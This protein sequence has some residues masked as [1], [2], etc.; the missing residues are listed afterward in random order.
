MICRSEQTQVYLEMIYLF[1][2]YFASKACIYF[3]L[4]L[5][6]VQEEKEELIV[7]TLQFLW[8]R[9]S[10]GELLIQC[11][12]IPHRHVFGDLTDKLLH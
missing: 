8:T 1:L 3:C 10:R 9:K 7:I 5:L 11:F 12:F 6:Y 2:H 4:T